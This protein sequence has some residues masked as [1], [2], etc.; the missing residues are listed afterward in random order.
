MSRS[1]CVAGWTRCTLALIAVASAGAPVG[2]QVC[3][4]T[5]PDAIVNFM[6]LGV[7]NY[8]SLNGIEAYSVA[9]S[10][11]N[12]GSV[13]LEFESD[14]NRHP[15]ISQNVYRL[16]TV[17]G[18]SRFE[19]V[20]MSWCFN[21]FFALAQGYC[22]TCVPTDGTTLGVRCASSENASIMG[23]ITALTPRWQTNATTGAFLFPGANPPAGT[24]IARRLQVAIS[25]LDPAQSGGGRYF[26]EHIVVSSHDAGALNNQNNASYREALISGSGTTWNMSITGTTQVEVPA[27]MAWRAAD[28]GVTIVEVAVPD[29]GVFY[30]A[31]KA[32]MI[33]PDV[34]RYEY[35]VENLTSDRSAQGFAV[36]MPVGVTPTNI[37]FHDVNYHSGDGPGNVNFDGTDWAT[38]LGGNLQWATQIFEENQSANALRWG[39]LYNFRFDTNVPPRA[40]DV[41]LTLFKPGAPNLVVASG[42]PIPTGPSCAA[43]WNNS[44]VVDSQDFFDFVNDFFAESADFNGDT[45]TNSQDFF[46]FLAAMFAGC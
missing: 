26:V 8:A 17:G 21:T 44:G 15:T 9:S 1:V 14:N 42:L 16:K 37:G 11:A 22:P 23:T 3:D 45:F 29:D 13:P 19:Q 33:L 28:S 39:T 24:T 38:T 32:T 4:S 43:D 41:T 35:A 20:G 2:A 7:T 25:D 10:L 12:V 27:I 31:G 34:W 6:G 36:P 5:G 40:G 46:D 30:V 18:A